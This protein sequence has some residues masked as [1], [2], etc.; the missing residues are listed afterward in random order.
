MQLFFI[1]KRAAA[2]FPAPFPALK[3]S[4]EG[5]WR[6]PSVDPGSSLWS[7]ALFSSLFFPLSTLLPIFLFLDPILAFIVKFSYI[8]R[9]R[10]NVSFLRNSDHS[11]W[12]Y[13]IIR[14]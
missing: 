9:N 7:M 2:P 11:V 12:I 6:T 10:F 13:R 1:S 14:K 3:L 8:Q 4:R 5:R